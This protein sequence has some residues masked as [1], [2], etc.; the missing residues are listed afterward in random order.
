MENN[1]IN[2]VRFHKMTWQELHKTAE[3]YG[4]NPKKYVYGMDWECAIF[5]AMNEDE[6]THG[7]TCQE[8]CDIADYLDKHPDDNHSPYF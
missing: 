2:V 6:L 5:T 8:A 1:I 3:K 7:L 4:I